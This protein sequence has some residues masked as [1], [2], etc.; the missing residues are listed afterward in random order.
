MLNSEFIFSEKRSYRIKRHILFWVFAWLY[1][2]LVINIIYSGIFDMFNTISFYSVLLGL[3]LLVPQWL[4]V[5]PLLYFVLPGYL[6]NKKYVPAFFWVAIFVI[7]SAILNLI[8]V[9][10]SNDVLSIL[11]PKKYPE[12]VNNTR[13]YNL[14]TDII[15]ISTG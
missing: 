5:Y 12:L 15:N 10:H 2:E 4:L 11:L 6:L 7:L 13:R 9:R 3:F 8:I 1:Y 14:R